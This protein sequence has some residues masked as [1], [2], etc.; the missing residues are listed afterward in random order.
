MHSA[1]KM[2]QTS[3]PI[4]KPVGTP[5]KSAIFARLNCHLWAFQSL[6]S[7]HTLCYIAIRCRRK[8]KIYTCMPPQ[9]RRICI[10]EGVILCKTTIAN[11]LCRSSVATCASLQISLLVLHAIMYKIMFAL[12]YILTYSAHNVWTD[13]AGSWNI[14]WAVGLNI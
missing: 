3:F 8:H 4:A 1:P 2:Q 14:D 6:S 13:N 11:G 7:W 10:K 5:T 9:M 12:H